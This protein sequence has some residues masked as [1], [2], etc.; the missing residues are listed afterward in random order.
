MRVVIAEDEVLL[1]EGLGHVLAGDGFDVVAAVGTAAQLEREVARH[2]PDLAITDIRMPPAYTDEGLVAALRI[3]HAHPTVGVVVLSQY[4][5]RRSATEL[6][7]ALN[8]GHADRPPEQG[9]PSGA[10]DLGQ[11]LNRIAPFLESRGVAVRRSRSHD[12]RTQRGRGIQG[13]GIAAHALGQ[14]GGRA[15]FAEHVQIVVAGGAVGTKREVHASR[16]VLEDRRGAAGRT[17][18]VLLMR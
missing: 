3:R 6:L 5:Q 9:W 15:H 13:A 12:I 8:A 11:R 10:S 2:V 7:A 4:V 14:E 16:E 18:A 17:V 1:R